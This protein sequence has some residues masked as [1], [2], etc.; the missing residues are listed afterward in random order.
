VLWVCGEGAEQDARHEAVVIDHA[1]TPMGGW[2]GL[3]LKADTHYNVISEG[4]VFWGWELFSGGR[5]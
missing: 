1:R 2:L 5:W 4:S 3:A